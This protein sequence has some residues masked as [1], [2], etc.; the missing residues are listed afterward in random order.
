MSLLP[1]FLKPGDTVAI[2]ATARKVSP[3]EM[4]PCIQ[5]LKNKKFRVLCGKHLFAEDNQFAGTDAQRAESLQEVLDNPEVKAIFCARGG[6]GTQRIIPLLDFTRLSQNPKWIIGFSDVTCLQ[7]VLLKEGICS[8]HGPM[9][10]SF[11]PVRAD[12]ESIRRTLEVLMGKIAPVTYRHTLKPP[13]VRQGRA[14]GRLTGG[15]LSLLNQLSGTPWQPDTQGNI[16]FIEDLDEYLYHID[17]MMQHLKSSGWFEGLAGLIVG[18]MSDMRDNTIPFGKNALQIIAEAVQ[19]YNFPIAWYF[20]TG[21]QKKNFP[22][23]QGGNYTL[24]VKGHQ[25]SLSLLTE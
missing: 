14:E 24:E 3:A 7:A 17:R 10:F 22:L 19:E 25:V 20:P 13:L 4:E 18:S 5:I 9:A 12:K 15:N 11:D 6:Y 16:L 1:P 23:I 8:V 21:H 2:T